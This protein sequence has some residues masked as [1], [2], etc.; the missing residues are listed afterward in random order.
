MRLSRLTTVFLLAA[1]A[2]AACSSNTAEDAKSAAP[3]PAVAATPSATPEPA[4]KDLA[5]AAKPPAVPD[6][7]AAPPPAP[8]PTTVTVPA[9]TE[10]NVILID[11]LSSDKNNA[12]DKFMASLAEPLV[13]GGKTVAAKGTKVQGRVVDAEGA[14]RVKGRASIRLVLNG[15]VD[16]AKTIAIVTKPFAVEAE[17][18]KG[19]DAAVVGGGTGIGAAI[20]AATGG[21]KGAGLGALIGGA[22]GAGT[23]LA[24]KGKE[25]EFPSESKLHFT[26]DQKVELPVK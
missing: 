24:T 7:P 22:A 10:L 25:V 26:L 20:G 3:N 15:I 9:G 2:L 13:I 12:G 8:K 14:G 6:K 23:V 17:A 21:K 11:P 18:T 5:A 16:G 19:R 1:F 4:V